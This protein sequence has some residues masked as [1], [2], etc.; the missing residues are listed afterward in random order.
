MS[1]RNEAMTHLNH[2]PLVLSAFAV[3]LVCAFGHVDAAPAAAAQGPAAFDAGVI[4]GLNAR[5]IGSATMSGR[6]AA[7][8]AMPEKDGK[9]T[10]YVGAASG[11][12]WKSSDGGTTF[13]PVFDKQPV[14]SIGDIQIDPSHHDTIWVGTGESWTRNSVS[15]G[16]GIYKST[17]GG[18][19]WTHMGL[20]NSERI[21]KIM[22]DPQDGN[23]VY[24]CVP[25]KLW[26]EM[27]ERAGSRC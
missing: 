15:I 3:A 18:E 1:A 10:L 13:K 20:N 7:L 4:S 5:N 9:L 17:D 6:I 27:A 8:A 22:V 23:T 2:H 11:G 26:S 12:V 24:A 14:Q 21:A 25:G 16:N 19:S